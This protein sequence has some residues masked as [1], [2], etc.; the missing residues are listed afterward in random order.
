M[1]RRDPGLLHTLAVAERRAPARRDHRP[2]TL[3]RRALRGLRLRPLFTRPAAWFEKVKF[4]P[5]LSLATKGSVPAVE[6]VTFC[7]GL[8]LLA[9]CVLPCRLV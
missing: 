5:S 1:V 7:V 2:S 4:H 3:A 9:R 6:A 8:A